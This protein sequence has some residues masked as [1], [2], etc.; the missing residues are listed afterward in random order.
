[1]N[2]GEKVKHLAG[3]EPTTSL[4]R[5]MLCYALLQLSPDV[6]LDQIS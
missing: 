6:I 3:I 4:L 5:G 2:E 1:M